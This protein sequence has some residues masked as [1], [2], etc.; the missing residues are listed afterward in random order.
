VQFELDST[1]ATGEY[2]IIFNI[3]DPGTEQTAASSVSFQLNKE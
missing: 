3:Q 2:K 1:Y